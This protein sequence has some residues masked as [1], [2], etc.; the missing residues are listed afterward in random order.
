M[1]SSGKVMCNRR[2]LRPGNRKGPDRFKPNEAIFMFQ[3]TGDHSISDR[4]ALDFLSVPFRRPSR[5]RTEPMSNGR[6]QTVLRPPRPLP[7][8]FLIV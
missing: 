5:R 4:K 3:Q 8:L 6:A 1:V 2:G 7:A